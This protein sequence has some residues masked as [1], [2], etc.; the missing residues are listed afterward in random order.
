M[1]AFIWVSLLLID[2]GMQQVRKKNKE[3]VIVDIQLILF[4]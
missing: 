1:S 3:K 4:T 2:G